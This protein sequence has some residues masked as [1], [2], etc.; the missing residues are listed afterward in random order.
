MA[1]ALAHCKYSSVELAGSQKDLWKWI[2]TVNTFKAAQCSSGKGW[3][4]MP[5]KSS[6][7]SRDKAEN[8]D[9][10]ILRRSSV[11]CSG[12][13][14]EKE[15]LITKLTDLE[16]STYLEVR[17]LSTN[18]TLSLICCV[19]LAKF[20]GLF[21]KSSPDFSQFS[22][23]VVDKAISRVRSVLTLYDSILN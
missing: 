22:L 12:Y 18:G 21:L 7:G 20:G 19:I 15:N 2:P 11:C 4:L 16:K 13:R 5:R 23:N 6:S 3:L 17:H 8:Q 9:S 10:V 14:K 1:Q